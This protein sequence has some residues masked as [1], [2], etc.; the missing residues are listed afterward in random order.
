[1]AYPFSVLNQETMV[2]DS[3]GG[4]DV[5]VVFSPDSGAGIVF[6]RSVDGASYTFIENGDGTISDEE[7]AS[8]WDATTGEAT[9]GPLAGSMLSRVK[10]TAVFWFGWKDCYPTTRVYGL[11]S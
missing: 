2:N 9:E 1:M 10:S 11:N 3:I 4:Q 7:T 6:D 5:L 8:I